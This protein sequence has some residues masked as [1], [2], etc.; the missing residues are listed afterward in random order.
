MSLSF[1]HTG[2]SAGTSYTYR[3]LLVNSFGNSTASANT[4]ITTDRAPTAAPA[5]PTC[6][7]ANVYPKNITITW[8]DYGT[9]TDGGDPVNYYKLEWAYGATWYTVNTT[10]GLTYNNTL[11]YSTFVAGNGI[12]PAASTQVFR[13]SVQ[14]GVGFSPISANFSCVCDTYPNGM[15]TITATVVNPMNVT[16][17][18][19]EITSA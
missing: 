19:T 2:F 5:T 12:F 7:L 14:N 8:A 18:W 1:V 15:G 3:L 11:L 16:L 17:T 13:L 10:I 4:T 6:N 9:A